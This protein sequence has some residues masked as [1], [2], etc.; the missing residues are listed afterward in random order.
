MAGAGV[1]AAVAA[2]VGSRAARPLTEEPPATP[3][4]SKCITLT[5]EPGPLPRSH[6][7]FVPEP[8]KRSSRVHAILELS[9][10]LQQAAQHHLSSKPQNERAQYPSASAFVRAPSLS[11]SS[12]LLTRRRPT[13]AITASA[14]MG[15]P[16]RNCA[17]SSLRSTAW[18][19]NVAPLSSSAQRATTSPSA[20]AFLRLHK[21][22]QME[23]LHV[24]NA[25]PLLVARASIT[26]ARQVSPMTARDSA[27]LI[28]GN[29]LRNMPTSSNVWKSSSWLYV[30]R[31]SSSSCLL[32]LRMLMSS[33]SW[34]QQH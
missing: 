23:L 22:T 32:L 26:M 28:R 30:F 16:R 15:L 11:S 20:Q 27:S 7:A 8:G 2:V 9:G 19:G 24:Q 3:L 17:A 6:R 21:K 31:R 29:S 4:W 18:L 12:A 34:P 14:P 5:P 10:I 1:Q 33:Q 25:R 13:A